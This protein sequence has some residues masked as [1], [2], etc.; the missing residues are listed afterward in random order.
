IAADEIPSAQ[1]LKTFDELKVGLPADNL[2][3]LGLAKKF[4]SPITRPVIPTELTALG[5]WA[6]SQRNAL[7]SVIRYK[8]VTM[9]NA[10]RLSNTKQQGVETLSYRFDFSNHLS[11]TG[12]W[13]K[14]IE[15]PGNAPA[16][17]VLN[18]Q[19]RKEAG[20]TVSDR[21]NRGE[22]VLALDLVFNGET[23]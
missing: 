9:A 13:L 21:I 20:E 11:A 14:G 2:T 3:T 10:W 1:E 18:D 4:A 19:G 8:P 12:V 7:T 6:A 22:Q 15:A 5:T 16:T 17:I 23:V